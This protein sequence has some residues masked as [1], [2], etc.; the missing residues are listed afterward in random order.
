MKS[1]IDAMIDY[2]MR[3]I[4]SPYSWGGNGPYF[5]C[6]GYVQECLQRIGRDPAYD[7]TAQ[8]LYDTLL[9]D[10]WKIYVD[11]G[12]IL[13]FGSATNR[14]THTGIALNKNFM[15]ECGGGDS[16][17]DTLSDAVERGAM[18]RIRRIRRDLIVGLAFRDWIPK[19]ELTPAWPQDV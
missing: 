15:L 14:I 12:S 9:R 18:V 6:S 17:T 11:R 8:M 5:D 4:G 10:G 16:T 1:E 2:G 3:F 13:F 7:Q 19:V